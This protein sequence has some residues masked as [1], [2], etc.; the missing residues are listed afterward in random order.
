M[1]G[2]K[3]Q[4]GYHE[5]RGRGGG[6]VRAVL[7]FIIALL[8]VL[9]AAGIAFV[10]FMEQYLEYTGDGVIVHWPWAQEE[11]TLPP[12]ASDPV[13][14]VTGP[15]DVTV[16]PTLEI[17]PTPTP[18]PEP[19]YHPIG[20]VTVTTA[21]LRDGSAAQ[22]VASAGGT[23]LVVEMKDMY[24]NLAWQSQVATADIIGV[25]GA[26]SR[27]AQA[28]QN[29]AETTDLYLVARIQG[30]RDPALARNWIGSIMTRGGN[31]WYDTQGLGWSSPANW[32]TADYL[33]AL[34]AELADMGFDE[35][36]LDSPGYPDSGEVK[37]LATSDN[38]PEDLTVPVGAF[39]QRLAD[40]L[41]E[42][43][44]VLSIQ[45]SEDALRGDNTLS[46]VTA[47]NLAQ[48]AGRVWL[49]APTKGTDYAALLTAAGMED[50]TGRIVVKDASSGSWYR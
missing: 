25:N 19:E 44:V 18:V 15:V 45:A 24:G 22:A 40:I 30:F 2:R 13:E 21:Q 6:R 34:C 11:E 1:G 42:K 3:G 12:I 36:L 17:D 26:D 49:T 28:V 14:V 5:Y 8:A 35:I 31:V 27:T 37:V 10:A 50:T 46:G 47:A 48:Y 16:E 29:L 9:L 41:E 7:L 4:Y 33:C 32:Q 39:W 20:A 38:R 23:A 43:G